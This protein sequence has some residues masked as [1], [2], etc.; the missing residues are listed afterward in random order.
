MT[1]APVLV[2]LVCPH[3]GRQV[4]APPGAPAWCT[5]K[6]HHPAAQRGPV[7]MIPNLGEIAHQPEGATP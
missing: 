3:C 7:P 1:R 6:A 5:R 2:T 4:G